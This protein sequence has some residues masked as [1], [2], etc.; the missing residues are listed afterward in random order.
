MK[1][2][3]LEWTKRDEKMLRAIARR[4]SWHNALEALALFLR[5]PLRL[6]YFR[7][8]KIC[9]VFEFDLCEL[10]SGHFQVL[11]LTSKEDF[12]KAGGIDLAEMEVEFVADLE[13]ANKRGE[14]YGDRIWSRLVRE[15]GD[16]DKVHATKVLQDAPGE[17]PYAVAVGCGG[18]G[19]G[20]AEGSITVA[21]VKSPDYAASMWE[22]ID[23][24]D[25][26]ERDL[27]AD[28]RY[29]EVAT[30]RFVVFEEQARLLAES[31]P[32][33]V[34]S[35]FDDPSVA[36]VQCSADVGRILFA[37]RRAYAAG[38]DDAKADAAERREEGRKEAAHEYC[39]KCP[40]CGCAH[41]IQ[42]GAFDPK[43][44]RCTHS[45]MRVDMPRLQ[46]SCECG[47]AIPLHRLHDL[48]VE[49]GKRYT[50]EGNLLADDAQKVRDELR[51]VLAENAKMRRE[52]EALKRRAK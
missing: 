13:E 1:M 20:G 43:E 28:R 8:A 31:A 9:S 24:H 32:K 35:Q 22:G 26:R 19:G 51:D 39:A 46:V 2:S 40:R 6:V 23:A 49:P 18:G 42:T 5:V 10:W 37:L 11:K 45:T 29:E 15:Y 25:W 41:L 21:D 36:S 16:E 17:M 27:R 44:G 50:H 47:L 48:K 12:A 34:R 4:R 52:I 33:V 7:L 30:R 38:R 14:C 3:D